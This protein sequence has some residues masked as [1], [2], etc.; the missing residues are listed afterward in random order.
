V[1]RQ[2]QAQLTNDWLFK[3]T[4]RDQ[5]ALF[6]LVKKFQVLINTTFLMKSITINS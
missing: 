1:L 4:P 3:Q 5:Q 2:F 6:G